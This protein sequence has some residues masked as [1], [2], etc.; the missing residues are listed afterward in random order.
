MVDTSRIDLLFFRANS[1]RAKLC[2]PY[3]GRE[4]FKSLCVI[5]QNP[6]DA[7][8]EVADRTIR[9]LEELIY[10]NCPEFSQLV[11]LNLFS[12][13]DKSKTQLDNL[14]DAECS[15]VFENTVHEHENVLLVYGQ[16]KRQGAYDFPKRASEIKGLLK[17]KKLWKLDIG[18]TYAPH[19]RNGAINYRNFKVALCAYDL[20]DVN[21]A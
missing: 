12:R 15:R 4:K 6:S 16:L 14:L 5:G 8:K 7:N 10:K 19:P 9:Y 3:L 11:V 18:A 1:H 13:V 17:G 20:S 21:D 2:L